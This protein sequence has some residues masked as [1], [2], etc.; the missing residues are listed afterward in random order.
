MS[1]WASILSSA[2]DKALALVSALGG[3]TIVAFLDDAR[4]AVIEHPLPVLVSC[5]AAAAFGYLV[6]AAIADRRWNSKLEKRE[7]EHSEEVCAIESEHASQVE[8]LKAE[9]ASELAE[10]A[11]AMSAAWLRQVEKKDSKIAELEAQLAEISSSKAKKL[12]ALS[13][14][15]SGMPEKRKRLVAEALE[16]GLVS[17]DPYD[18]DA[19]TLC[20][21]GIFGTAPTFAF[22]KKSDFSVQPAV[23]TE[24]REHRS[25]WLGM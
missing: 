13:R 2:F 14:T 1:K 25:E 9:H 20:Q 11:D 23:I 15:F 5:I 24:I 10:Q 8:S 17:L 19:L 18:A 7:A 22:G 21:Q 16:S 12:D 6:G 4:S 3:A